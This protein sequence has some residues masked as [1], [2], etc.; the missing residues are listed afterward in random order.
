M[1]FISL[2]FVL[3]ILIKFN[4]CLLFWAYIYYIPGPPTRLNSGLLQDCNN[5][6]KH[7]LCQRATH[8]YLQVYTYI[9]TNSHRYRMSVLNVAMWYRS[10]YS[11]LHPSSSQH[12]SLVNLR[13][14]WCQTSP[15]KRSNPRTTVQF[16]R[17]VGSAALPKHQYLRNWK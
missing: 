1:L 10:L 5:N 13:V 7:N 6:K 3:Q 9:N 16:G 17:Y 15:S 4:A 11:V 8:G 2:K 12:L 14:F